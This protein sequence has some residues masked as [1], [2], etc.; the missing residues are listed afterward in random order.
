MDTPTTD[1]L[2]CIQALW[3]P[4]DAKAAGAMLGEFGP[5]FHAYWLERRPQG[6]GE[7][8]FNVEGFIRHWIT[9]DLILVEI[10]FNKLLVGYVLAFV[11]QMMFC[12]DKY[13][14]IGCVYVRPDFRQRGLMRRAKDY[15]KQLAPSLDATHVYRD[16]E[17]ATQDCYVVLTEEV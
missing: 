6:Y 15:L 3:M 1:S 4:R 11:R 16:T 9:R 10:R 12:R 14:H 7:F 13:L 8:D 2:I 5:L 17:N